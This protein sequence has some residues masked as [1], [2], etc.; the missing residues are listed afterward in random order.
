MK[1]S[2]KSRYGTRILVDI[3]Q[4]Q[5][6]GPVQNG[7]IAERQGISVQYVLQLGRDLKATGYV[8]TVRGPK[9][10]LL[11]RKPADEIRLGDIVR[12]LEPQPE[13]AVCGRNP[14]VCE[15]SIECQTRLV[16]MQATEAMY[17]RLNAYTITDLLNNHALKCRLG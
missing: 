3:A 12:S 15:R 8:K 16:W 11:L 17:E 13:L 4:N 2:T 5:G 14:D 9:G 6:N 10:G 1:L 7:D